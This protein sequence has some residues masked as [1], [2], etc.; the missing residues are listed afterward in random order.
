MMVRT[1]LFL[2]TLFSAVTVAMAQSP[3]ML[4][5]APSREGLEVPA[6]GADMQRVQARFGA[7]KARY[8]P[9]GDPPITRWTY[10]DFVVVFEDTKVIHSVVPAR[11]QPVRRR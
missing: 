4:P 6:R 2:F 8:G 1:F 10:Q 3:V 9:V 7:P 11:L 5:D